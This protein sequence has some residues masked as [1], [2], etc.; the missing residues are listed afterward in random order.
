MQSQADRGFVDYTEFLQFISED[1]HRVYIQE[2]LGILK[3]VHN[4]C[5]YRIAKDRF[6]HSNFAWP[7]RKDF[8]VMEQFNEK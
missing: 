2:H 1:P 8:P 5:K 3:Y 7:M 4:K 6:F